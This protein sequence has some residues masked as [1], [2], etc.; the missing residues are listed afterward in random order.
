MNDTPEPQSDDCDVICPYCGADYQAE[1][2]DF[3][4]TEREEECFKCKRVYV[5]YQEF[6]VTH[7]TRPKS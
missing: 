2:E 7:H 3:S 4:E 6:V 1:A 5:V